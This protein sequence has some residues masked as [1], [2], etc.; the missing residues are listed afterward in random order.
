[1]KEEDFK[2][3]YVEFIDHVISEILA[4]QGGEFYNQQLED[5]IIKKRLVFENISYKVP[6]IESRLMYPSDALNLGLS[7]DMTVV[8]SVVVYEDTIDIKSNLI[9]TKIIRIEH[10]YEVTKIPV[11]VRSKYCNLILNPEFS[12][13]TDNLDNLDNLDND[14]II[15]GIIKPVSMEHIVRAINKD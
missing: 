4:N 15:D 7:Y 8:V 3:D 1:M 13:H 12:E 9:E 10:D 2:D 14:F 5:K 11:M 6:M